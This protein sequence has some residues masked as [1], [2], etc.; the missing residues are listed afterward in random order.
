MQKFFH[1][2]NHYFDKLAKETIFF[3]KDTFTALSRY[4]ELISIENHSF[5]K[6]SLF[7]NNNILI[8][9]KSV[10]LKSWFDAGVYNIEHL[11]APDGKFL[12]YNEFINRYN[13]LS[14]ILIFNGMI[15]SVKQFLNKYIIIYN[16]PQKSIGPDI[17]LYIKDIISD[18]N[19]AKLFYNILNKNKSKPT[20]IEKWTNNLNLAFSENEWKIIFE[21]SFT[22]T[23]CAKFQWFKTRI[24]HRI[25]GT[26]HLLYKIK[27]KESPL[28]SFCNNDVESIEH[29]FW[30]CPIVK[31]IINEFLEINEAPF[32]SLGIKE[33]M[34]GYNAKDDLSNAKNLF[35]VYYTYFLFISTLK[36]IV[37]S[38]SN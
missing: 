20:S 29:L 18:I 16:I 2:G 27:Y 26:N 12:S 3:W 17:L 14:N 23:K 8:G 22:I 34:F 24:L 1:C 7:Y 9:S 33:M 31:K 11:K 15:L 25:I 10:Y 30:L 4:I 19:G 5:G 28:C 21:M 13:V 35:L 32:L 6:H 38:L 36:S 37:L